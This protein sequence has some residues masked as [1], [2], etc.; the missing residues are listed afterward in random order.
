MGLG[1]EGE[2]FG[3]IDQHINE[4][5]IFAVL[6]PND[7]ADVDILRMSLD[8]QTVGFFVIDTGDVVDPAGAHRA[9]NDEQ[10][11]KTGKDSAED[12]GAGADQKKL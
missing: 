3:L 5:L 12:Q 2:R 11:E 4:R 6:F 7:F 10:P 1:G 9:S 8:V